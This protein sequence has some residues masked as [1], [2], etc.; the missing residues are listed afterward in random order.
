MHARW[1][2]GLALGL[3]QGEAL[4]LWWDDIDLDTGL[5][6]IR[7]AW[8]RQRGRGLVF[9]EP[10]T[11]RG[12]RTIPLPVPLADALRQHRDRQAKE[13]ITAGPLSC[14]D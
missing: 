10:K 11:A 1:L 9:T 12:K 4:G 13:R 3:R 2:V 6:Q 7:R 8:Q 14:P 5:L